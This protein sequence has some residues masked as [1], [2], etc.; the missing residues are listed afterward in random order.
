MDSSKRKRT[1]LRETSAG[2]DSMVDSLEKYARGPLEY[3]TRNIKHKSLKKTL[4]ETKVKI[5]ES[6]SQNVSTEILL[7]ATPGFIEVEENDRV[8]KIKQ[9]DIKHNVDMNTA[10]NAFDLQLPNFGPY[11]IDYSRNGRFDITAIVICNLFSVCFS[12]RFLL[13]GG[14]KGHVAVMDCLRTSMGAELQL[15]EAIHDVHYLQNETQFAFA[16]N[17]YTY[18]HE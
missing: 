15:Q 7:D 11:S 17:K 6:A 13:F 12:R 5:I 14:S 9:Q 16:Q 4:K 8:Y 18:V 3:S 10:K 2:D 1:G